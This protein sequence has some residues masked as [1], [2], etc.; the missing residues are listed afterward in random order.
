VKPHTL[1]ELE[2]LFAPFADADDAQKKKKALAASVAADERRGARSVRSRRS[3]SAWHQ[4]PAWHHLFHA[5]FVQ[6][7][8]M[9]V[10][11]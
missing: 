2:L 10:C 6:S 7:R 8:S 5:L 9:K 1:D 11:S 4:L 3:C